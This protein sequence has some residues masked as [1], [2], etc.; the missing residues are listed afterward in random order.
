MVHNRVTPNLL[1]VTLIVGGFLTALTI[2]QEVFPEFDLDTVTVRVPYPGASPAEVEQ[3]IVLAVEEGIRGIEGVKQVVANA[4]EGLGSVTA[5]LIEGTDAQRVFQDIQQQVARIRTFPLDSEDP[6]VTLDVRRREVLD[7]TLY[8]DV[9]EWTLRQTAEAVR[10]RLLQDPNVTQLELQ[11]AR[12]FE[13]HLEIPLEELRRQGLTLEEVA[14]RVRS[15]AVEI[16]GGKIETRGGEIL[17]RIDERKD[18]AREFGAIPILTT[19]AGSVVRLEDLATIREGFEDT[20]NESTFN[21]MRAV[22]IEVYRV[23]TETPIGVSDAVRAALADMEADLPPGIGWA[24]LSDQSDIYR[25]RLELLLKNALLGLILVLGLLGLFLEFKLAFWVT[26][27]I[28]ISF[29]GGLVLLPGLDATINMISM[30]AFIIALGIVVDDAIVAGENIYEYRERGLSAIEAAIRG[31]RD[32]A[33]PV[34]FAILTNVVAFLPLY[35][36]PGTIGKIWR[37][38]PLV[39]CTVFIV[40]LVEA[41]FILPAHLAHTRS[42]PTSRW[43]AALHARQQA[44]TRW[45][46]RQIDRRYAPFLQTCLGHRA[47]TLALGCAVLVIVLA[48]LQSGRLGFILMPRVESDRSVAT[49]TLP[50]GSPLERAREV[51]AAL[52]EA[53]GRVVDEH[54]GER[55]SQGVSASIEDNVIEVSY[56][57]TR[58]DVRPLSTAE[59][60]RRWRAAM[61]P[62]P[63]LQALRFQSDRGGPGGGSALTIELS[64]RTIATLDAASKALAARLAEFSIVKDIDDGYPQ[65]KQQLDFKLTPLGESLGFTA[66]TIASQVRYAF[67]GNEAVRQQ[68]GRNEVTVRVR[69]PEPERIYE[70]EVEQM[71]VRTPDGA[72]APL[73]E[74]AAA[75]WGRAYTT[76]QRRDGRRTVTVT[77]DV[78]PIDETSQV[79]ATLTDE[80]LPQLVRDF[81]GLTHAFEG[82]Q[83]EFAEGLQAL[84]RGLAL[85][86]L[87]TYVLLAIP[88]VSYTQPLLIMAI[89]PF[90]I[91]GAALGHLVM[92][93]SM[94]LISIMG[95]VAL[96]GVVINDSLVLVDY[97]NRLV[98]AEGIAPRDAILQAAV[99]R[100]RP[101]LLTTLT[102]FGGL[103]P[104]IFE[105]S[106]QARFMIPM[107]LSLGFGI[108]F[109]TVITLIILPCL[110]LALA[111]AQAWLQARRTPV[112]DSPGR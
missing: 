95:V 111:D 61:Q 76:I 37:V 21:G 16:P 83:V 42:R 82:R 90:G 100:F 89:I 10:D 41:L 91:V 25:Q 33:R 35:F 7:L 31:A 50:F 63:G 52:L 62:V 14:A 104:M 54:G 107:A 96:C 88:F 81:P 84:L 27:G 68:R 97:A 51:R 15:S 47:L 108:L 38:I 69:R 77:A 106:R 58:P 93:Y 105:T 2:K 49:A 23:G 8:G 98:R 46:R 75:T 56:E 30:F 86:L 11:G 34:T 101:I 109:A 39:V 79:L 92:G 18:W 80:V 9:S 99:R 57:L 71:V 73:Y 112:S 1:M 3:G 45:F 110:Y 67:Q 4:Q 94:S 53:G 24:I 32:V 64:H 36:I 26:M 20:D 85:S 29:L 60:T 12:E 22:E 19:G 87:V 13:I 5:E 103:A 44:F 78:D 102:T 74:V 6:V 72:E 17:L 59:F 43:T 28:P 70:F 66:Q 40:S 65:G 55:L 48:F